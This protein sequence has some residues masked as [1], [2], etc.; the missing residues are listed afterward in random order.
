MVLTSPRDVLLGHISSQRLGLHVNTTV[1]CL[2][3]WS[4][5]TVF[6]KK[7]HPKKKR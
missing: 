7:P 3:S 5:M 6:I 1:H 4:P 2:P